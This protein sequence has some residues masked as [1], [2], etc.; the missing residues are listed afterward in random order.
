MGP[1]P[2][3]K[4]SHAT[5]DHCNPTALERDVQQLSRTH[6]IVR[7]A[8]FDHFPY[9]KHVECGVLMMRK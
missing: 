4:E 8:F 3:C 2:I 6:R 7:F 1:Q 9:T 5:P